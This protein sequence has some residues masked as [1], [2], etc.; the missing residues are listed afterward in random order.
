MEDEAKKQA[1][2]G[3]VNQMPPKMPER[4][5]FRGVAIHIQPEGK[6]ALEVVGVTI[7]EVFGVLTLAIDKIRKDVQ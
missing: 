6:Y 4:P 3:N 5:P 7:L 2:E 1:A